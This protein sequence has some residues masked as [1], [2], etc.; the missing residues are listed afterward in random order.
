MAWHSPAYV[1]VALKSRVSCQ[2]KHVSQSVRRR[3]CV[4]VSREN[5]N[6]SSMIGENIAVS[7]H[8]A[9]GERWGKGRPRGH[10]GHGRKAAARPAT[11]VAEKKVDQELGGIRRPFT[12]S[13]LC[14]L[15]ML[16]H[17]LTDPCMR[18]LRGIRGYGE[19]S[20][21]PNESEK[22]CNG[23]SFV[24]IK[25]RRC[26]RNRREKSVTD[27]DSGMQQEHSRRKS[28][29]SSSDGGEGGGEGREGRAA[30]ADFPLRFSV[31]E[32]ALRSSVRRT[33]WEGQK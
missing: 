21:P 20:P 10:S 4:D 1:T 9:I 13:L 29:F 8:P 27:T 28:M 23:F 5:E 22:K 7:V 14:R 17:P 11:T 31:S 30:T 26:G 15:W 33:I 16:S 25:R 24:I 12:F 2:C 32:L 19:I 6:I 18:A 3:V